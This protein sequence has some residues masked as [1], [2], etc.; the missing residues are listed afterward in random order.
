[1]KFPS[2]EFENAV[3][4][5]CHGTISDSTLA[6][7][8]EL[9][10]VDADALDEYLWRVE[11]HSELAAGSLRP[12]R[13]ALIGTEARRVPP[14]PALRRFS[15]NAKSLLAACVLVI[16]AGGLWLLSRPSSNNMNVADIGDPSAQ[17]DTP[18]TVIDS[19]LAVVVDQSP[20]AKW[21]GANSPRGLGHAIGRDRTV[22]EHGVATLQLD[23]EVE[24]KLRGPV[25]LALLSVD[26]CVVHRGQVSAR[27]PEGAIGF[28]LDAP[29]L[30]VVDLGTEFSVAVSD[31]GTPQ[32]HVFKGKV[33]AALPTL[34]ASRTELSAGETASFDVAKGVVTREAT[35]PSPQQFP[36]LDR[37]AGVPTTSGNIFFLRK[38]PPSVKTGTF[39]HDSILVFREQPEIELPEPVQV[40]RNVTN[41]YQSS[42]PSTPELAELA[43]GTRVQSYLV[44]FDRV[45]DAWTNGVTARGVIRFDRP[46][47]GF[48]AEPKSLART[49]IFCREPDTAY[50]HGAKR[51]LEMRYFSSIPEGHDEVYLSDDGREL[52]LT[53]RAGPYVD[54]FRVLVAVEE[55]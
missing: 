17:D 33:R 28:R 10:R 49:D 46:I 1:M 53:L 37:D 3:S 16:A 21:S 40:I 41:Q 29:G 48:V 9:M 15:G 42:D 55:E 51:P 7:L 36:H 50:E 26:H 4:E 25:E 31:S 30:N 43:A 47:L 14:D 5:L 44:H 12:S 39:E 35:A 11:L 18:A 2:T 19:F 22:L 13:K 38:P 32:V 23:N 24:L 27:V 54:Q 8:H 34:P 6:D 20:D 45:G 52:Q